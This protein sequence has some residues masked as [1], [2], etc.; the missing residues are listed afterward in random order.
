VHKLFFKS[1]ECILL[2]AQFCLVFFWQRSWMRLL[3]KCYTSL[4][5]R[6]LV[7]NL[8]WLVFKERIRQIVFVHVLLRWW[9]MLILI[10]LYPSFR[11][12][13]LL[14][15]LRRPNSIRLLLRLLLI[16][17][18]GLVIPSK[19]ISLLTGH[20]RL[21]LKVILIDDESRLWPGL[22][23]HLLVLV[24]GTIPHLL[25]ELRSHFFLF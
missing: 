1:F 8:F 3:T 13:L 20:H 2:R 14:L 4:F 19:V 18:Y 22:G 9:T 25:I 24:P 23:I 16:L 17:L 15:N 5:W 10:I 7:L 11:P 12:W 21:R 6:E